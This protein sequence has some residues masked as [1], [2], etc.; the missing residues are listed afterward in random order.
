[1]LLLLRRRRRCSPLTSVT[2]LV[3]LLVS[4]RVA[5]LLAERGPVSAE[6]AHATT[7]AS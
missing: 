6:L 7:G 3:A 5:E 1:L 4:S 2:Y